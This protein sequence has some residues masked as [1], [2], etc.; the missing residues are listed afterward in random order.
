MLSAWYEAQQ[1]YNLH[2][3]EP[4]SDENQRDMFMALSSARYN[5]DRKAFLEH[6]DRILLKV[7]EKFPD[8]F[9][10]VMKE[11]L[12]TRRVHEYSLILARDE[13]LQNIEPMWPQEN[14]LSKPINQIMYSYL[15]FAKLD[16]KEILDEELDDYFVNN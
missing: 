13:L 1:V 4:F 8:W 3:E 16:K 5:S 7:A 12:K 11:L 2:A 10:P 15:Q 9:L 6:P 14:D